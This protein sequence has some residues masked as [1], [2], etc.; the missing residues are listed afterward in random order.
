MFSLLLVLHDKSSLECLVWLF[1][2]FFYLFSHIVRE[3]LI[4]ISNSATLQ[5]TKHAPREEGKGYVGLHFET[6]RDKFHFVTER[7]FKLPFD[8]DDSLSLFT[9]PKNVTSWVSK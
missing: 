6:E 4:K 8:G 2:G 1:G 7:K 9:F 5:R 3:R